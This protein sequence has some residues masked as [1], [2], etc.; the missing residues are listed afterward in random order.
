MITHIYYIY[1]LII[2]FTTSY[3]M[4][5]ISTILSYAIQYYTYV[6]LNLLYYA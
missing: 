6:H 3:F 5:H 2:I 1:Y 4:H